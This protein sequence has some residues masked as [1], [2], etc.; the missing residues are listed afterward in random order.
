MDVMTMLI[1]L[2]LAATVFALVSGV[3]TMATHHDVGR[4]DGNGWMFRRVAFQALGDA[5]RAGRPGAGA[6]ASPRRSE[7]VSAPGSARPRGARRWSGDPDCA[8]KSSGRDQ[9]CRP[10][11]RFACAR[12]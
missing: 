7:G 5:A 12:P 11:S 10:R 1:L 2:A 9:P 6:F 4:H 8:G 3:T